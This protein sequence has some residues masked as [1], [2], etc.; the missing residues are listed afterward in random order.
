MCGIG[1]WLASF[2]DLVRGNGDQIVFGHQG[3][4]FFVEISLKPKI[5]I[6]QYSYQFFLFSFF[7]SIFLILNR[8]AAATSFPEPLPTINIRS[9]LLSE[10]K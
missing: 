4:Y 9:G 10:I 5:P 7:K 1:P 2:R 8:L 3:A 6:G